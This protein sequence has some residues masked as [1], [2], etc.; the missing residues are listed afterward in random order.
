MWRPVPN[1]DMNLSDVDQSRLYER[2]LVPETMLV[3]VGEEG[4]AFSLAMAVVMASTSLADDEVSD[5]RVAS[6]AIS[7][8]LG[9]VAAEVEEDIATPAAFGA[10][11]AEEFTMSAMSRR[12]RPFLALRTHGELLILFDGVRLGTKADAEAR[13]KRVNAST[14]R[15]RFIVFEAKRR[16]SV[17][18]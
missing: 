17:W 15:W 13:S 6:R 18:Q 11:L 9:G 4:I 12:S 7:A 16:G 3:R 10:M 2:L 14:A 5:S 1:P 8:G